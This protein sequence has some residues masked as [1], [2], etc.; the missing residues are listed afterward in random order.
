MNTTFATYLS[1]QNGIEQ[2]KQGVEYTIGPIHSKTLRSSFYISGGYLDVCEKNTALSALHPQIEVNG[3]AY[4]YVGIYETGPSVANTQI[5]QQ[6]NSRFQCVTQIPRIGLITSLTLQA[7]WM[8]KQQRGMES[9]FNNPVYMDSNNQKCLNP[10]YYID[11]E[12]NQH[13]FTPEMAT[14]ERFADLVI[15]ANT[16]TAFLKDSYKPYFLLN[17]RVTKEIGRHVSVAFCANNL[18]QSNP[19]RYRRSIQKYAVVNPDLY[20]GAEISIRF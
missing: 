13:P 9:R 10:V 5:W 17:L 4:P 19:K 15:R 16:T 12:G 20:Y 7:V 8:D 11:G 14:D 6:L 3:K 18:L 2:E 1:P